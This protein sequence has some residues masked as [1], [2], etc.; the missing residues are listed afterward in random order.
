MNATVI[1]SNVEV[2]LCESP[3]GVNGPDSGRL[4]D[5]VRLLANGYAHGL[6]TDGYQQAFHPPDRVV[7]VI[8]RDPDHAV[9]PDDG[10]KVD[11]GADIHFRDDRDVCPT[12]EVALLPGGW[13]AAR[14]H[15]GGATYYPANVI[16]GIYTHT[17]DEQE[18][19]DWFGNL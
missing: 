16:E 17:S 13:V 14:R 12:S 8:Q 6:A 15:H 19:A 4:Y 10:Y 11:H 9:I 5:R 7:E 1:D 3:P 18:S 2:T